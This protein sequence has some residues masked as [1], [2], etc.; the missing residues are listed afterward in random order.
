MSTLPENNATIK[1]FQEQ[2]LKLLRSNSEL[3][4]TIYEVFI[5][6]GYAYVVGGYVRD[7]LNSTQSRDVDIIIDL[8]KDIFERI[9]KTCCANYSINRHGGIKIHY[10]DFSI[11]MWRINDNW[12]FKEELVNYNENNVLESIAAGCFYNYDALVVNML[13]GNYNIH[14]YTDCIKKKQLAILR[15]RPSY[16]NLNPTI[17]ANILRAFYLKKTQN[18]DFA[19]SVSNYII[20]K[21]PTIS[22][23]IKEALQRLSDVKEGYPKY[24]ILTMDDI[25]QEYSRL[26]FSHN[27]T[28]HEHYLLSYDYL[29]S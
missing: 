14:Y 28:S 27:K 1:F 24:D 16:A 10:N 19:S 20:N 4:A 25:K 11:D 7:L 2:F 29:L 3:S 26:L 12:A 15:K 5:N 13:S 22:L 9:I 21:M 6:G 18:L 17:E 23:D 8:P